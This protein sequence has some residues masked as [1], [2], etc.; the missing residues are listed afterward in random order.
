L[1]RRSIHQVV[2]IRYALPD[3]GL[4]SICVVTKEENGVD[5]I[6]NIATWPSFQRKSYGKTL[7]RHILTL[8]AYRGEILLTGTGNTQKPCIFYKSY[9]LACSHTIPD[10]FRASMKKLFMRMTSGSLILFI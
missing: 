1:Q 4:K 2:A 9:G 7:L 10:F 3:D 8:Y 5:K 6:R